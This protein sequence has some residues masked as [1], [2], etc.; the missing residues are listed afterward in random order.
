M[1][2]GEYPGFSFRA[3]AHVDSCPRFV[4]ECDGSPVDEICIRGHDLYLIYRNGRTA[5]RLRRI[6]DEAVERCWSRWM[7]L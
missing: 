1:T 6:A 2:D 7:A 5:T 4:V 3:L